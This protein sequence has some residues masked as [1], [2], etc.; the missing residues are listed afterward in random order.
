[1]PDQSILARISGSTQRDGPWPRGRRWRT[2]TD[3]GVSRRS[4]RARY[5]ASVSRPRARKTNP[6]APLSG[7]RIES[8]SFA[9]S[10]DVEPL[11]SSS[12]LLSCSAHALQRVRLS[13]RDDRPSLSSTLP[14]TISC[15]RA[16]DRTSVC[17]R[18]PTATPATRRKRRGWTW[19]AQH[20]T[21][22]NQIQEDK[23]TT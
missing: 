4:R 22:N 1:M 6:R 5:G 16:I 3:R 19:Q 2:R 7:V 18:S 11:S 13:L 8:A 10:F 17:S 15:R 14:R 20:T 12:I 21:T 9:L 23:L